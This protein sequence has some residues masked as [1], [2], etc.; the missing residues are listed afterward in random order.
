VVTGCSEAVGAPGPD[1][2]PSDV[3]ADPLA[4]RSPALSA[5]AATSH[6][7]PALRVASWNIKAAQTVGLDAI[8]AQLLE[9]DPDVVL[10]QEVD[11][12]VERTFGVDQPRVIAEALGFDHTFAPTLA[13]EGGLYGIATLS[14]LP[15][16]SAKRIE[17]SNVDAYEPRTALDVSV[18]AGSMQLRLVNHHADVVREAAA[19]SLREIVAELSNQAPHP[20]VFAGDFNQ[21]PDDAGLLECRRAKLHDALESLD[22]RPTR[23]KNR[24]DYAFVDAQS[25]SSVI[26]GSVVPTTASD[27]HA[28]LVE[29]DFGS[30]ERAQP[31]IQP[32]AAEPALAAD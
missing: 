29:I 23:G 32:V 1:E 26:A 16:S 17:L 6:E 25:S 19:A 15:F 13:L 11:S 5:C 7:L 9:L 4:L 14:R 10:L 28:L 27:H 31:P 30:S 18:C 8:V 24:I 20:L 21:K 2:E 22:P 3:D 12:N